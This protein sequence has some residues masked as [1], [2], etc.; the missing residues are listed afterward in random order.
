[1]SVTDTMVCFSLYSAARATTRA[2]RT[3]LEPWDLTYPQ[4]LVL[5]VLWNDGDQSVHSLGKAM[6]LDSGT[7]SPLIRRLEQAGYVRRERRE[8][9]ARVV[10][11]TLTDAGTALRAELAHLPGKVREL[12]LTT[13]DAHAAELIDT[14][15]KM[16]GS[17]NASEP[18]H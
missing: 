15:Q 3:L 16:C 9:D 4:Y 5:V 14:L 13:D 17:L 1:M 2:Y 7:L 11:V 12:M 8:Q 6:Q 18:H 10:T